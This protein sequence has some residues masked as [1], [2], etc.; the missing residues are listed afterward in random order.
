MLHLLKKISKVCI[1]IFKIDWLDTLRINLCHLP[2]RKG[3]KFPI[4]LYHA[5]LKIAQSANV[6]I[7]IP[8]EKCIFGMI[9]MGCAYANNVISSIGIKINLGENS[10]LVFAGSAVIGNG[11]S[12]EARQ[13][14]NIYI[15]RNFGN[16]G[17]LTI[18]S[19]CEISIGDN[20][21]CSWDVS[22][23]DTDMHDYVDGQTGLPLS[24]KHPIKLGDFS[25]ICQK[26][27]I[28]KGASLPAW[29]VLGACSL[30]SKDYLQKIPPYEQFT[31]FVGNPAKPTSKRI[32]RTDL[33]KI[34]KSSDWMITSG[35]RIINRIPS[36]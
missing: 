19:D 21:S 34:S 24:S 33:D 4:L 17:T 12:I 10:R 25:W 6:E 2:L 9:K 1:V 23:F 29:S 28:L 18:C 14:G 7:N 22:I 32:K 5:Q 3:I 13:N 11:S 30:L 35:F 16:T 15:G 27:I 31:V 20:V 36:L 26:C 8:A